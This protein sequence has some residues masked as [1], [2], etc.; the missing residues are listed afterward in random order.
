MN[1]SWLFLVLTILVACGP[2]TAV[3]LPTDSPIPEY[4]E[5]VDSPVRYELRQPQPE[6]LLKMI[7]SVLLMEEQMSYHDDVI[8]RILEREPISLQHLIG[9]DFERYYLDGFPSAKNLVTQQV[10]P[11]EMKSFGDLSSFSPVLRIALLEYI[12]NH[13]EVLEDQKSFHIPNANLS[14]YSLNLDGEGNIEWLVSASH[15]EISLQHWFI[16]NKQEDGRYHILPS[17][18]TY[19][20]I[21]VMDRDTEIVLKDLTGDG[22]PEITKIEYYYFAGSGFGRIKVYTWEINK[23]SLF[24]SIRLP[25]VPPLYGEL[26]A[27]DYT[28]DDFNGDGTAEIR[29]DSPQFKRFGCQWVRTSI[30]HL[31]DQTLE[32]SQEK[33]PQTDECLIAR[34]LE[35]NN[36]EEQIRLYQ[37]VIARF[38][39]T[40]SPA[41]KLA[42][43]LLQLVMAYL[44]NGDDVHALSHLQELNTMQ[45]E[46]KFLEFIKKKYVESSSPSPLALCDVLYSSIA[47]QDVPESI[48]SEI[49]N[50]LTHGAYPIDF[51]PL[52]NLICPFPNV[53]SARLAKLKIPISVSP[54]D[55]LIA[56]GYAFTWT[57]SLNWDRDPVQEWL[58]VLQFDQPMLVLM[59]GDENWDVKTIEIY[60]SRLSKVESAV[61]TPAGG[62]QPKILV[63]FSGQGKYCKSPNTVKWLLILNPRTVEYE[64][65]YL[66]NTMTYSLANEKDIQLALQEFSKPTSFE[67]FEAPDWYYLP[68]ISEFTSGRKTILESVSELEDQVLSKTDRSKSTSEISALMESLPKDDPAARVLLNRLYYLRGLNYELAGQDEL[69]VVTYQELN[70]FSPESLWS[71]YAQIRVRPDHP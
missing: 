52:P 51:A 5:T 23:L 65:M 17:E 61:Y 36:P 71:Q 64:N 11:W 9:E 66:C 7:D 30:Y 59:D 31:D 19:D 45:T 56:N 3:P 24:K 14:V 42:W 63:I 46:G 55:G 28:I 67:S 39:S 60:S 4:A 29:V 26:Y 43:I 13:Q 62:I 69:A 1:P 33:I 57:Q 40:S 47:S 53:L 8:S 2:V 35:S 10:F 25:G 38:N 48:G 68:G 6:D 12:N 41:D 27:S 44:A 58:G 21:Q 50:D 15:E 37:E 49:D 18:I 54:I 32:V 34:A 20:S 22:N 70:E 16:I